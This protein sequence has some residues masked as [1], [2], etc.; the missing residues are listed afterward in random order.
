M[1]RLLTLTAL[2][3]MAFA[4]NSVLNRMAL[5]DGSAGPAAFAAL[6]LAAGA[7]TLGVLLAARGALR[8]A[9]R[10]SPQRWKGMIYL[11]L[12]ILAF[13]FAYITL[14]AG[15]GALILFGVVQI[16]MFAAALYSG[17]SVPAQRWIGAALALL[18]LAILLWPSGGAP[19]LFGAALMAASAVGW[20]LYSILGRGAKDPLAET[21]GNFLWA[22]PVG[23][24]VFAIWPDQMSAR[25]ALLAILSGA[26]TS[27][28]GYALW[29]AIL[30]RLQTTVAAVA[31]LSV[32]VIAVA[33]GWLLLG[34]PVGWRFVGAATLVLG[35]I[36]V[37]L[38]S[39]AAL[40]GRK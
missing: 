10:P 25:G 40:A 23:L 6:R 39:P 38:I 17:V 32:P 34:E 28:L 22:L 8:P 9:M 7:V 33:G 16:T 21:G 15:A 27:G 4:A 1:L 19:D 20:G 13:S 11:T 3:M 24:A 14:E 12:Y 29:Y 18:G 2:T 30:P 5:A 35:G 26:V 37:A 31:Q 36:L